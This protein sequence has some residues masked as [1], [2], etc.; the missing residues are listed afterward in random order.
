MKTPNTIEDEIDRIRA[1][2]SE[3]TKDMTPAQYAEHVNR[4]ADAFIKE[5]GYKKVPFG[6]GYRIVKIKPGEMPS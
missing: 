4:S 1:K 6:I 5:M 2:I 3:E